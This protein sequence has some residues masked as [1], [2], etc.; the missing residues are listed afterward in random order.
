MGRPKTAEK[1]NSGAEKKAKKSV[2]PSDKEESK[3][4]AKKN[5]PDFVDENDEDSLDHVIESLESNVAPSKLRISDFEDL[6]AEEGKS[7]KKQKLDKKVPYHWTNTDAVLLKLL[8]TGCPPL[9]RNSSCVFYL[10]FFFINNNNS[11]L[12]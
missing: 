4:K 9:G 1:K 7:P 6:E 12:F 8:I 5:D 11:I 2:Q 3:K 10:S